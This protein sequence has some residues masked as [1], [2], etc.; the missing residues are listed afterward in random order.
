MVNIGDVV[1]WGTP[2][3][4]ILRG[5][6]NYLKAMGLKMSDEV[7]QTVYGGLLA[8]GFVLTTQVDSLVTAYPAVGE[9]GPVVMWALALFLA[10][11]GH[12]QIKAKVRSFVAK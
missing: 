10:V 6:L 12:Y 1:L 8:L 9:W 3:A 5:L 2:L 4:G 11:T 7:D